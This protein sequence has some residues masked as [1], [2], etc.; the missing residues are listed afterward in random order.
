MLKADTQFGF[1]WGGG[2][3]AWQPR[4]LHAVLR[5]LAFR[6][7][8]KRVT[9]FEIDGGTWALLNGSSMKRWISPP[10]SARAGFRAC[11]PSTTR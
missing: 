2:G 8:R 7:Q 3:L 5:R 11:P 6:G 1:R 4:L 9:G 10:R